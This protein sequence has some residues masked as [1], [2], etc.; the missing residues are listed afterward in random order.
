MFFQNYATISTNP[1]FSKKAS[2]SSLLDF[3]QP[4]RLYFMSLLCIRFQKIKRHIL[5]FSRIALRAAYTFSVIIHI[6]LAKGNN[7]NM[8]FLRFLEHF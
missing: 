7:A 3:M 2:I 6:F 4:N 8:Y 1:E 5:R